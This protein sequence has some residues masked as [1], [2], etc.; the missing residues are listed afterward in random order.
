MSQLNI[1]PIGEHLGIADK[2]PNRAVNARLRTLFSDGR[3]SGELP[4]FIA[5]MR[6][7]AQKL[8]LFADFLESTKK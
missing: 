3:V 5:Y 2:C 1:R 8:N 4:N 6:V 7:L